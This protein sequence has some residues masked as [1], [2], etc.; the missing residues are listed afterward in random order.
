MAQVLR[1]RSGKNVSDEE[2][3]PIYRAFYREGQYLW[4][5][6][7]GQFHTGSVEHVNESANRFCRSSTVVLARAARFRSRESAL[8]HSLRPLLQLKAVNF[9]MQLYCCW[10][11]DERSIHLKSAWPHS[12]LETSLITHTKATTKAVEWFQPCDF[13]EPMEMTLANSRLGLEIPPLAP[14]ENRWLRLTGPVM[15]Q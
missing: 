3:R 2:I 4:P 14:I 6:H 9:E 12:N 15:V 7:T 8:V 13:S 11:I 10:G 5:N 1:L